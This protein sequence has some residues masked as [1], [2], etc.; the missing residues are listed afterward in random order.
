MENMKAVRVTITV[1]R[2]C[3]GSKIHPA[4]RGVPVNYS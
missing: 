4:R 3:P 1:V 2:K